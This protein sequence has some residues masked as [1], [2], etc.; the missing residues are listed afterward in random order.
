MWNH[1][2]GMSG[3]FEG[4]ELAWPQLTEAEAMELTSFLYFIDY[5]GRPGDAAAG[6]RIFASR[7][8]PTCHAVGGRGGTRGPDLAGLTGFASPLFVAQAIWNHGPSMLG[9]MQRAGMAPP[10]LKE[11][12]LGDL[13]AFIR[14]AAESGPRERLLLSPGNPNRGQA[15]YETRGCLSCHALPG[16][17]GPDLRRTDL[18]RSAE[19]IAAT[20]WNH[21]LGMNASMV[22][23][24]IAWPQL[25]AEELA[26]LVAFL[27]YLPFADPP[28]SAQ[29]GAEVFVGRAC[30]SCHSG[31]KTSG[32][33]GPDLAGS[34]ATQ[35]PAALVAA[36]WNH[37]PVMKTA[38]LSE[39]RPWPELSG[40]NLRDLLAYLRPLP[41]AR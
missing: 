37:A 32:Q 28:G 1:V 19:A 30:A 31:A 21:A 36:M 27:Y 16:H 2:P 18:H 12:D 4:K 35:S 23:Q 5:L 22:R 26:D 24:G 33:R 20:M 39:G 17:S 15:V 41:G 38:I 13:S 40:Q 34:P 29:R 14:Q 10:V 9:S 3:Q 6:R 25:T 11:G 7:G 8:C